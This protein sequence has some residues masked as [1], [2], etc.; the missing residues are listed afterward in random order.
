MK[1]S[2]L[3]S[4]TVSELIEEIDK[5]KTN[6]LDI[7]KPGSLIILVYWKLIKLLLHLLTFY[8]F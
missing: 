4:L 5:K 8:T 2:C 3:E 6:A 7:K 1:F